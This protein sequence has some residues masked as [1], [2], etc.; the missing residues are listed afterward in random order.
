MG[1]LPQVELKAF[2]LALDALCLLCSPWEAGLE[3]PL[4]GG[5]AVHLPL[6]LGSLLHL[7]AGS[8]CPPLQNFLHSLPLP[9]KGTRREV[10]THTPVG[11]LASRQQAGKLWHRDLGI[12][13]AQVQGYGEGQTSPGQSGCQGPSG[14]FQGVSSWAGSRATQLP[15]CG[16]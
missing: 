16:G 8:P 13:S 7:Q 5:S 6:L 3:L 15:W 9:E 11:Q 14:A 2:P 10:A 4:E 1:P 12:H